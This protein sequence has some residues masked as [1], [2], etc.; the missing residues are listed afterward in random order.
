MTTA[1][2]LRDRWNTRHHAVFPAPVKV[3]AGD[4][5]AVRGVRPWRLLWITVTA[6]GAPPSKSEGSRPD[7]V[8][9]NNPAMA[10]LM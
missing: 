7:T 4:V 8:K 10:G 6:R 2:S 9:K 1:T 3:A 5:N